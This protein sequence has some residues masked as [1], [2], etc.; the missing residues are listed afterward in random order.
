MIDFSHLFDYLNQLDFDILTHICRNGNEW[1]DGFMKLCTERVPWIPFYISL[2]FLLIVREGWKRATVVLLAILLAV[3]F[4]DWMNHSVV[5]QQIGRLRPSN[6]LNPHS[7]L[8]PLADGMRSRGYGFPSG[9]GANTF[10]TVVILARMIRMRVVTVT[11]LAWALLNCYTR[12]WYCVHY[13]LDILA[14]GLFGALLGY[15]ISACL[16]RLL[17]IVPY[18]AGRTRSDLYGRL[19]WVVPGTFVILLGIFSIAAAF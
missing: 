6:S 15:L 17:Q 1:T 9:H 13:P 16:D 4:I 3:L 18:S 14:G 12:L 5:R 11:L 8:L 2:Y 19:Q 7:E 10:A